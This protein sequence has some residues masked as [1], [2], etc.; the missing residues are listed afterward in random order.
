MSFFAWIHPAHQSDS[1]AVVRGPRVH[2]ASCVDR[3]KSA[4]YPLAGDPLPHF[5]VFALSLAVRT[6]SEVL[7]NL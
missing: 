7:E 4:S 5:H 6:R 2:L 3:P 1:D